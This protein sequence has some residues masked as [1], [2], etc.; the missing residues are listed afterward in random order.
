MTKVKKKVLIVGGVAGGA[1][2]AARL[3]RLNE[4]VEIIM[5]ERGEHVSFANC[6]LPYYIG[7]TIKS[8][9]ALL[10]QTPKGLNQRYEMD[11]RNFSEV[12]KID[13]EKK[14]VRVKNLQENKE[15]TENYDYLILSP[16]AE[17]VKPPIKGVEGA[18][19]LYT[20]RNVKDTDEIK[21]FV[22]ENMPKKA[23]VVGG[24]FIGL[25][26]TE[27]LV[28]RGVEVTIVEMLDQVMSPLDFEMASIVHKHLKAKGVKLVLE[29]GVAAFKNNGKVVE[30]QSGKK[31]D[32]DLIIL[33]IGVRPES[34]LAKQAGLDLNKRGAIKVDKT[35][36]TVDENIYAIGDA[37]EIV[38][39]VFQEPTMVPLAWPANRQG[40]I[41]ADNIIKEIQG[42]DEDSLVEY[43]GTLGVA[44][45][46]V[47][48]L[49]VAV[50]GH[51]EKSLK[52]KDVDYQVIHIHPKSNAGYYPTARQ[53]ALKL[54]YS[55]KDGRIL[56]AQAVGEKGVDKRIDVISTAIKGGVK[57]WDLMNLELAYAPPYSSAKDP[58]NMLGYIAEDIRD[59]LVETIQWNEADELIKA[60]AYFLDVRD[61]EELIMGQLQ[62]A[63]NIPLSELRNR[64]GELPKEKTIHTYC[65]VGLRGYI[66]ARILKQNGFIVKNLDGGYK[67]Y[68]A[69]YEEDHDFFVPTDERGKA[70]MHER[71][72]NVHYKL[73]ERNE[74]DTKAKVQKV[75]EGTQKKSSQVDASDVKVDLKLDAC[76][77]QCPGPIQKVF[78]GIGQIKDGEVMQVSATDPAFTRDVKVWAGR[79][80]NTILKTAEKE[81]EFIVWVQKGLSEKMTDKTS[82]GAG[83]VEAQ[84]RAGVVGVG[85]NKN[86]NL[87]LI[88]FNGDLDKAIA[89]FII[90]NGAASFGKKVTI[91]FTFWGLNVIRRS[92]PPKVRKSLLEKMFGWMMP[93]GPSKLNLS[94]MN[95]A[96]MGPRMIKYIMNKKNVTSL[97]DLMKQA[98]DAGVDLVACSMSMDIMGIKKEEL[99]DGVSIGG[100]ATYLGKADESNTNLFV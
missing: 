91:F 52:N 78:Q 21:K 66:A 32:A 86:D 47:F 89:A 29:D 82:E 14:Q 15:Y 16:G 96:G 45:A 31:L 12:M 46:K 100:V 43:P 6:G 83:I 44:I 71:K 37:V 3:R 28:D 9:D 41:V 19:N 49:S 84:G 87:S 98:L 33:S 56:G 4:Y 75:A 59:G 11:V 57:V 38:D 51:N 22:D 77:L 67:T 62:G 23:V 60:G 2:A 48:D 34:S 81:S 26:M 7:E 95:M 97:E 68:S 74:A 5:F 85:S 63:V 65:Q 55:C 94:N 40:R 53:I 24:G 64:L 39:Y 92:D 80:G 1:T 79:T 58:V 25:E 30:T 27:N 42:E 8:R 18:K 90:A 36:K 93:K 99:I 13:R 35:M 50:T 88:V 10:V 70:E 17:P 76:G 69:V 20:L 54:I 61:P 72:E 73:E